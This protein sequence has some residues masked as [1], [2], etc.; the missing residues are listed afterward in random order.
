MESPA[1]KT[2]SVKNYRVVYGFQPVQMVDALNSFKNDRFISTSVISDIS[3]CIY[4]NNECCIFIVDVSTGGQTSVFYLKRI[5]FGD[6][7]ETSVA[8]YQ[9]SCSTSQKQ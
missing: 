3:V 5:T 8:S 4:G 6:G 1:N 2:S 7:T 9:L